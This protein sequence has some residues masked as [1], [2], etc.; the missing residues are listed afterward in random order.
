[1]PKLNDLTGRK[2]GMLTVIRR[3]EDYV[4]PKG[5]H[6]V[7]W[8][9]ICYCGNTTIVGARHLISGG[10]RSCG[11]FQKEKISKRCRKDMLGLRFGRL[12]VIEE[13]EPRI[14]SDGIHVIRWR[15]LCDCGNHVIVDGSLLRSGNTKSCGCL[16]REAASL[17]ATTH[18]QSKTRLYRIWTGMKNRCN[19][20]RDIDYERYGGR[21]IFVCK[22]WMS[23]FLCFKEWAEN[24]GYHDNLSID[25]IDVDGPYSPDNCR[26]ADCTTQNNNRRNTRYLS[27]DGTCMTMSQ[28]ASETGIPYWKI[29]ERIN[30]GWSEEEAVLI[31]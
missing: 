8:A 11:C 13:A 14:K 21:G 23:D 24:S 30:R 9:C 16:Q 19:N 28:W 12:T 25:R 26:R 10:I 1:M 27:V 15:C 29:W 20:K 18:G 2:F 4:S 22:E 31:K 3:A 7:Q 17:S 6:R 5:M